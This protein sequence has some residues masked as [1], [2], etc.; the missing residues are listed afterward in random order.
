MRAG[1][2]WRAEIGAGILANLDRIDVVEI[3]AEDFFVATTAEKRALRVLASYVPVVV[4]GTS[5]GLAS[6]ERVDAR[7]LEAMARLVEWL[8]PEF[9]SEHLA[10]VRSNG[11]EIGHL[12]A[13]PRNDQTL[14]GLLR[15][16]DDGR[17]IVGSLPLLENVATLI[18]PPLSDY[19]ESDWLLKILRTTGTDLLLDLHNLYANARNF[20]FDARQVVRAIP[21]D[22]IGAIHLAGGRII[23][24]GRLLD[25][26]RHEVPAGVFDLLQMI[27]PERAPVIIERDGN[28]PP[29]GELVAEVE[30]ARETCLPMCSTF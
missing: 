7:R 5:L 6:T 11:I 23:D 29:I 19:D 27:A 4:H 15:N 24:G 26:H 9:W 18:D 3:M 16:L 28:Y 21:A 30:R 25:D 8:R 10:F 20:G 22:R 2:G 13:P 12:A 1:L 14:E 17:R